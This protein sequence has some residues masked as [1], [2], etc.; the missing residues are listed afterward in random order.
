MQDI[1]VRNWS[2]EDLEKIAA[3]DRWLI[4][5]AANASTWSEALIQA[6]SKHIMFVKDYVAYFDGFASTELKAI[7]DEMLLRF[8]DAQY[9]ERPGALCEVITTYRE[10]DV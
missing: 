10:V 1:T 4:T 3:G 6:M 7:D 9:T 2:A 5:L 8:I